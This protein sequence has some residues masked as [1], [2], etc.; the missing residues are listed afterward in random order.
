MPDDLSTP[1]ATAPHDLSPEQQVVWAIV[2]RER[3]PDIATQIVNDERVFSYLLGAHLAPVLE[4]LAA[5]AAA[6]VNKYAEIQREA[7]EDPDAT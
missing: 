1:R 4:Q 2:A 3:G 5:T 7:M 6:I